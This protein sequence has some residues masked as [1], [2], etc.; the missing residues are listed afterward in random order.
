MCSEDQ[1]LQIFVSHRMEDREIAM[2]IKIGLEDIVGKEK[3][4]VHVCTKNQGVQDWKKD[5]ERA[6]GKSK[7]M[8]FLY[9]VEQEEAWRWC[10]YEI[11]LFKGLQ[12]TDEN[13]K[14]ICIKNTYLKDL[15]SPI[16]G[17]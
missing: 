12:L 6:I 8:V 14:L 2:A 15:P 9:T 3:I 11:G 17:A 4:F 13:R 7:I 16:R 5:I 10:M 1:S